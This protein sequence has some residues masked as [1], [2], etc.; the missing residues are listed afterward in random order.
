LLFAKHEGGE[1]LASWLASTLAQKAIASDQ[2]DQGMAD[3]FASAVSL[4]AD[5]IEACTGDPVELKANLDPLDVALVWRGRR[6][7]LST[8]S[9]GLKS[10][11]SWVADLVMRLERIPWE[12]GLPIR[13]RPFLLLLDEVDVH[14]HPR[15]QR[16]VLPMVQRLF[17]KAQIFVTT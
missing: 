15:W 3:R 7:S 2:G 11:L 1:R 12:N 6:T 14:L 9:E 17:P 8:L 13:E 10:I 16:K 5:A 4:I